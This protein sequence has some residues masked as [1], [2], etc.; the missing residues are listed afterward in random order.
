MKY[1]SCQLSKPEKNMARKKRTKSKL[2]KVLEDTNTTKK[3]KPTI[4]DC[5]KW[6]I[7][8]NKEI[9]DNKLKFFRK[10]EIRR[11]HG[12]WGEITA[13]ETKINRFSTLSLNNSF[14]SKKHFIEVLGHEMVHHHQ[15]TV[16]ND[17]LTH[18]ES[19]MEWKSKF[20]KFGMSLTIAS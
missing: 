18:G 2:I 4:K 10:I 17:N 13:N 8:L 14:K 3:Y 5:E 11:R 20:S 15:W 6:F 16:L 9:F 7:V 12:C 1:L 19:F